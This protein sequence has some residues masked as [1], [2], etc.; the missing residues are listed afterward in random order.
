MAGQGGYRPGSGRKKGS[1]ACIRI[2][3]LREAFDAELG[4]P[5]ELV[6]AKMQLKLHNDFHNDINVDA[7]I[8]FTSNMA[9]HMI[10]PIPQEITMDA[11]TSD[12]TNDEINDKLNNLLTIAALSA[13]KQNE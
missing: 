5:F 8:R 2:Q 9:K 3:T 11:T 10:Q 12:L 13:P 1:T 4:I 6:L 7:A